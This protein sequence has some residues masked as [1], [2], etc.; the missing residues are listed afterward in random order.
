MAKYTP[1]GIYYSPVGLQNEWGQK[2]QD[3]DED[4]LVASNNRLTQYRVKDLPPYYIH[5]YLYGSYKYLRATNVKDLIYVPNNWINHFLRDDVL[6]ISYNYPL[7][8]EVNRYGYPSCEKYDVALFGNDIMM[9]IAAAKYYSDYDVSGIEQQIK[10]KLALFKRKHPIE[11]GRIMNWEYV[12]EEFD[13]KVR[14]NALWPGA[15]KTKGS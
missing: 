9:F 3:A 12:P 4:M 7:R 15:S 11:A 13:K 6:Y 10:D 5:V 8:L 14:E 2:F 1:V